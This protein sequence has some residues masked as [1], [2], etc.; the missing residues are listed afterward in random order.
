MAY[1]GVIRSFARA[2]LS[3]FIA[4]PNGCY[5]LSNWIILSWFTL[6]KIVK[7][8]LVVE[9]GPPKVEGVGKIR[10]PL[11]FLTNSF[12]IPFEM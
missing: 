4:I 8:F 7:Y 5:N 12:V 2:L 6:E 1:R 11:I 3:Q 9:N 10:Y